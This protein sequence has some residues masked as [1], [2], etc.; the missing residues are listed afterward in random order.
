[1]S[2]SDDSIVHANCSANDTQERPVLVWVCRVFCACV[3]L[4][5]LFFCVCVCVFCVVHITSIS[6]LL[7]WSVSSQSDFECAVSR[8][9][10][11]AARFIKVTERTAPHDSSIYLPTAHTHVMLLQA[12]VC[13]QAGACVTCDITLFSKQLLQRADVPFFICVISKA[14]LHNYGQPTCQ[15]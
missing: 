4:T 8:C 3:P 7:T 6:I 9:R 13:T 11:L 12:A 10:Q 5:H 14:S 1:M 15:Q 2:R